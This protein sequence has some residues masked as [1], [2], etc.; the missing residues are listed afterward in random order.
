TVN[1][2]ITSSRFVN[3]GGALGGN[4]TVG[5]TTILAGGTLSPGNSVGTLTVNGNLVF[6]VASLYMVEVQGNTADRT[7][8]SGTATLA[9]TVG[10]A[11]LGGILVQHSYTILSAAAGR[12]GTFD[13]LAALN[14]PAFL[15]ASLAYTPTDVQLNLTS[16]IGQIT[17]L[18]LNQSAVAAALD[19]SFNAGGGTLPGL[20]GL[21]LAQL[22]AALDALSGEGVS[23]TQE[24]AFG[25]ADMFTSIMM[26][27]GA[28][29]RNGESIDVNGGAFARE[30]LQYAPCQKSKKS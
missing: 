20:L 19:N 22:P 1:G 8:V 13:S 30:P 4:G 21:S 11:N 6:A 28:F 12:S 29:W 23:G 15:T 26:D 7:N 10:V 18:T 25:A 2:P 16:G 24:T 9:G 14:L 27:Q 3:A 5:P 17:G